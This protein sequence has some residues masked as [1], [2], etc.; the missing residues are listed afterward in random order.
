MAAVGINKCYGHLVILIENYVQSVISGSLPSCKMIKLACQRWLDDWQR[1]DL[2]FDWM[3][4]KRFHA[5]ASQLKHFKGELAGQFITLEPWQIFIAANIFG[6]KRKATK[7]RRYTY[8]DVFVPRKNGKTTFA[9]VIAL[10]CMMLDGE[11]GAEVYAAAVD[12]EQAKICF[13]ASKELIR[14]SMFEKLVK[15]YTSSIVYGKAASSYKPLSKDSKNKDGLNPSCAVC[16]ERHAWQNNDIYEVLKTG[17]GARSQPL[18]FSIS[19]AGTDTSLPYYSDIQVL[20]DVMLGIKE[21]DNHFIMLYMPDDDDDWSDPLTWHKVN[22]NYGVSLSAE[23]MENEYKE[24]QMRGGSTLA[25]FCTKNLNMW[26]DAPTV[27]IS[28]DTVKENNRDID[29]S[30]LLGEECYVG[31]DLAAKTDL[32]AV[33]F[34]FPKY[35]AFKI[36]FVVPEAKV[37]EEQDRVD[38]RLWAEQGWLTVSPGRVIDEDWYMSRLMVELD[39]YDVRCITYDPWGMWNMLQKFGRYQE[40]LMEYQQSIRYMSVPTKWYESEVMKGNLNFMH[41]PILRWNMKNVV[42]Y[43]DPNANIK[44]DKAR[45]RNKIDGVVACVDAIGGWL[46]KTSGKTSE[47]YMSHGLRSV[48]VRGY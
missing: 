34:F 8:A 27:W 13:E 47:I 24:A 21:K 5:F 36:L 45:S 19:T 43:T 12:R 10:Y 7:R 20:K 3:E 9:A 37:T 15:L 4:V 29:E 11:A 6:W 42:I 23:Y 18:I 30:L 44:L 38:Y 33:S 48:S 25:A 1:D 39:K 40:V 16:D 28:D 26:V 32:T 17:V 14:G 22:P 41:N 31:I 35:M 2:Y 46:N